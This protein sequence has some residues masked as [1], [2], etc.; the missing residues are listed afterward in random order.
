MVD[1]L[2]NYVTQKNPGKLQGRV[3]NLTPAVSPNSWLDT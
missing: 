2:L 1:K 3:H